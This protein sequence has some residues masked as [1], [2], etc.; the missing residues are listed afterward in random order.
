MEQKAAL[1]IRKHFQEMKER[2]KTA[3]SEF[4]S[5]LVCGDYGTGKTQ[6]FSTCPTPVWIDSFDPGGTRT[7]ALQSLIDKGD[8]IVETRYENDDW[9]SP[10]AF[11]KWY[12]TFLELKEN[13][14]FNHIGTYGIDSGT[15][16]VIF[17]LYYIMRV[18]KGA[19]VKPHPGIA[20]YKSDYLWQQLIAGNILRKELMTL[21]CHFI[22]TGHVHVEKDD[23]TGKL[24]TS[25]LMWGKIADQL[26][27]LFDEKYL[28]R[29]SETGKHVLQTKN[30]GYHKAET[31]VGGAGFSKFEE[32]N[33]RA[34]LKK[35]GKS[36]KDKP[37]LDDVF[38]KIAN[39]E[40]EEDG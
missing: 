6:L 5:A 38:A 11:D 13:G 40:E 25:L 21:P 28:M 36:Y 30:D 20:P 29:V 23:I 15:N 4:V 19:G 37:K 32:P 8:I 22:M 18:G 3:Y 17:L 10:Q 27:L 16:W 1:K 7:K 34:L 24:E 9:E 39:T 12:R 2:Y 14:F 26:P 33:F 31:R 35:A